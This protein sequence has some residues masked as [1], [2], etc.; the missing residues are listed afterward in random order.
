MGIFGATM[1]NPIAYGKALAQTISG[2]DDS[3]LDV[4]EL[5]IDTPIILY[6][7][8]SESERGWM[9]PAL[10]AI[11]HMII[12]GRHRKIFATANYHVLNSA[13]K[14]VKLRGVS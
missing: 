5:A 7:D 6:D 3:Y 14:L 12:L 8:S 11:L 4:L 2:D 9:V 1:S 10:S 13:G